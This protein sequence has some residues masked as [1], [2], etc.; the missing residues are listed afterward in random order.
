[1]SQRISA[2]HESEA[3]MR[4]VYAHL[5]DVRHRSEAV[6]YRVAQ[7]LEQVGERLKKLGLLLGTRRPLRRMASLAHD[8]EVAARHGLAL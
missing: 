4:R 3:M 1:M 7:H 2:P 5:G 6:E 8:R